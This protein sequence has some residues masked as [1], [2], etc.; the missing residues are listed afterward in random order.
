ME[1]GRFDS[2]AIPPCV[3][4]NPLS[5]LFRAARA[6]SS[7]ET[8][9]LHQR[10]PVPPVPV[11]IAVVSLSLIASLLGLTIVVQANAGVVAAPGGSANDQPLYQNVSYLA[12]IDVDALNLDF[13]VLVPSFVPGPFG[14]EPAVS[15]GGGSYSLYW[16][17]SGVPPTF[18]QVSGVVGGA[19]PA[20]SPA[21]LN[22]ELS[23]NT[24]VQGN[25]AI[26]DITDQYDAVWWISGGVLYSV[27]SLNM[28]SDSLSL[29]N[30]LIVYAAPESQAPVEE[31]PPD[32]GGGVLETPTEEPD[33]PADNTDSAVDGTDEPVAT[34]ADDSGERPSVTAEASV[35]TPAGAES[36]SATEAGAPDEPQAPVA[37]VGPTPEPEEGATQ[38]RTT[39]PVQA[40]PAAGSRGSSAGSDG[41]GGAPLP[42]FGGDGTGGTRDLVVPE[43]ED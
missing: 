5:T 20:G 19:L 26:R 12:P 43:P 25:P 42:V 37:T 2:D 30:S 22:N 39:Q 3:L 40:D 23:I 6:N 8:N 29:A 7:R 36:V 4:V 17:N 9:I 41:T 35:E 32:A 31:L 38:G 14:G 33:L 28:E 21:D 10:L 1:R 13:P 16:M 27:E 18:L 15:S 24:T 11:R 34:D